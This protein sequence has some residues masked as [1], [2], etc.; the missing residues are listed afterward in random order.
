[1]LSEHRRPP[2]VAEHEPIHQA[3]VPVEVLDIPPDLEARQLVPGQPPPVPR[4]ESGMLINGRIG[5]YDRTPR[6][7][8]C[9]SK[10]RQPFRR[11]ANSVG[12]CR[13][14]ETSSSLGANICAEQGTVHFRIPN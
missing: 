10:L 4:L 5:N 8:D 13:L 3:L 6:H 1:M 12:K 11:R 9:P 2:G 7:C 14:T